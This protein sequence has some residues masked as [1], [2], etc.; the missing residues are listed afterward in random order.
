MHITKQKQQLMSNVSNKEGK[1]NYV[2]V[3]E[4]ISKESKEKS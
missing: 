3:L 1:I 4:Q 2:S